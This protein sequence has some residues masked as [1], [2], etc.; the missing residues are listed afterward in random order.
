MRIDRVVT[1]GGTTSILAA[2]S[3]N[4]I[5]KAASHATAAAGA[6]TLDSVPVWMDGCRG[7]YSIIHDDTCDSSTTG[8]ETNAIPKMLATF[9]ALLQE[10][11]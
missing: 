7:A 1:P 2:K 3:P 9:L 10:V 5:A 11:K 8:I 4:D 6:L